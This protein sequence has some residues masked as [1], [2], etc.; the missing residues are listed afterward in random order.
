VDR[1]LSRVQNRPLSKSSLRFGSVGFPGRS[2]VQS[3][4]RSAFQRSSVPALSKL[5]DYTIEAGTF[6]SRSEVCRQKSG[7]AKRPSGVTK[8]PRMGKHRNERSIGAVR[9]GRAHRRGRNP[10]I[11]PSSAH[12]DCRS[13]GFLATLRLKA[14]HRRTDAASAPD[15]DIP[16][17]RFPG[18]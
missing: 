9:H 12:W 2:V 11:L 3:F 7:K 15:V 4:S 14:E 13:A 10:P 16:A 5:H 17:H 8:T 18:T 6:R 1:G